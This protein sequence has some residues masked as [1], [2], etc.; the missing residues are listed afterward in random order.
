MSIRARV[1]WYGM[2]VVALVLFVISGLFGLLLAGSVPNS[3]DEELR[4]R[5]IAATASVLSAPQVTAQTSLTPVDALAGTEIVVMVLDDR[6][7]V[8]T[9]TGLVEGAPPAIPADLLAKA[10]SAGSAQAT[11]P[12]G[13]RV[14]VRP[15][16][17]ADL[18]RSGFVV[19]AQAV[20][21][22]RTDR[23]GVLVIIFISDVVSLLAAAVAIWLA[24]GR[25][26]RPLKQLSAT[27]DEVG[28]SADLSRRLPPVRQRDDLGRLTGSFNTMMDRLQQAYARLAAAFAAQQRFT[29]DASH[30]LRTPLTTIRSNAGFLHAHPDADPR[31][32]D[33]AIADISSESERMARLVDDLL[34]LA[35]ADGGQPP[36]P[37]SVDLGPLVHDVVAQAR[38][39]HPDREFYPSGE[40]ATITGDPDSLRRLLW[41]L[42]DNAVA[43]TADGGRIWIAV[44]GRPEGVVLYVSDNGSG[45]PPG[46][47]ERIFDRFFRADPSRSSGTGLGLSIA[48]SIVLAHGGRIHAANNSLGGATFVVELSPGV[49]TTVRPSTP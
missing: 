7:T 29:A 27:A 40:P 30:E 15:W 28:R 38:R 41:I 11:T 2:S 46:L 35:R 5:A 6:G 8:L 22:L 32:R 23:A 9:T 33:A 26:L 16:T 14:H 10:A 43:H 31:D 45:I 20:Q 3:Q 18:G 24:T 21:R 4:D 49:D 12:A 47:P 44:T 1:T 25:A 17:R 34:T 13:L 48:Q 42:I 36:R 39:A 37:E 19:A